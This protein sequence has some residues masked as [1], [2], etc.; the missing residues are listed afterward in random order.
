MRC[1]E[2]QM[3]YQSI[4]DTL[5]RHIINPSYTTNGVLSIVTCSA[6]TCCSESFTFSIWHIL[7]LYV[8][9]AL[10]GFILGPYYQSVS[11]WQAISKCSPLW[12]HT[13]G[14]VQTDVWHTDQLTPPRWCSPPVHSS[15]MSHIFWNGSTWNLVVKYGDFIS[16]SLTVCEHLWTFL[17]FK[18]LFLPAVVSVTSHQKKTCKSY[19]NG[20]ILLEVCVS[21]VCK[22]LCCYTHA[23]MHAW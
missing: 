12:H 6:C 9:L 1:M 7:A 8:I 4:T 17:L 3:Q 2:H 20:N 5:Q 11:G 14:S 13:S 21:A 23:F 22:T 15:L 19:S 10:Y 16:Y 18:V